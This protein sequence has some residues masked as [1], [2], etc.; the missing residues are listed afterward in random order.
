M[1]GTWGIQSSA[2]AISASYSSIVRKIEQYAELR[3]G[4]LMEDEGRISYE[5]DHSN[6]CGNVDRCADVA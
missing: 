2:R 4:K 3:N 6:D 1:R 5:D